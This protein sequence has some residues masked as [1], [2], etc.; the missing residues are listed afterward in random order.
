MLLVRPNIFMGLV[1]MI[2]LLSSV[3]P[4]SGKN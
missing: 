1:S 2:G 4:S 3:A